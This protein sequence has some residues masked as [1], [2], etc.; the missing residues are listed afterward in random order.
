[1]PVFEYK[2]F[3][4]SGKQVAGIIDA[5]NAKVARTRLRRQGMFPSEVREQK[6][7]GGVQGKGLNVEIDFSKYFQMISRRDIATLTSQLATLLGASIP[8]SESLVALVDQ[9]EKTKLK[10]I[11]S[12]VKEQVNGG[13][14]LADAIKDHPKVFDDLF[15]HMVRAGER[16][17][18]L[19]QVLKRLATFSDAQVKLQGSIVAAM[20]YPILMGFVGVLMLM[21]LFWGVI[22]RVRSLFDGLG[23]EQGLP[24]VTRFVFAFGD[25]LTSPWLLAFLVLVALSTVGVRMYIR[26]PAGRRRFDRFKLTMP[27]FGKVNRLVAISRFCRTLATLLAS[28]VP[29][30]SALGIVRE[31]LGNV[32]LAEAVDKASE[33]IQEGHSIAAPLKASGEFPPLV[34]H[35][36]SIGERTGDLEPMLAAV[37]DSYEEQVNVTMSALTSLL[38][39]LMLLGLGGTVFV[40]A[41]GLLMPMMNISSRLSQM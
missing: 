32:I 40:V 4:G 41:I 39:P 5:D 27:I 1:M 34:T 6:Q 25:F 19:D 31:V 24:I 28:G 36:I 16:T 17:G 22:P 18:A 10:V 35:M 37:A 20:A 15:V 8:M 26:T 23:G 38:G 11:L 21:G 13:A 12:Q 7:G 14:T 29:I 2:G 9:T 33:N 30:V 3:D